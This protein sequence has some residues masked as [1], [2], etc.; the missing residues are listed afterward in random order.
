MSTP[1][2]FYEPGDHDTYLPTRHTEG[3]WGRDFQH[4]GPPAALIMRAIEERVAGEEFQIGRV[5]Y[6]ILSPVP[7]LPLRTVTV[8]SRPGKRVQRIEAALTAAGKTVIAA[9][10]W[11]IRPAPAGLPLDPAPQGTLTPPG[12]LPASDPTVHPGWSCGFLAAT[13]WRFIHG[14]YRAPGP[15]TAWVRPKVTLLPGERLSPAQRVVLTADSANGVSAV[16]DIRAWTFIPPELTVHFLRPP[17]GEWLCLEARSVVQPGAAGLATA[18][19]HDQYGV[20]AR[21]A[22]TLLVSSH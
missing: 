7:M 16:L 21:S 19:V 15:A 9:S 8:I 6:E 3:P 17:D 1:D 22:Q 20:V 14:S 10:A 5:T 18:T 2:A 12:N 13:E 4:G 11:A